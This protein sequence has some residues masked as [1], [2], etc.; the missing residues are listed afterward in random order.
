MNV[1]G[2]NQPS[3]VAPVPQNHP[4]QSRE[5]ASASRSAN[6]EARLAASNTPQDAVRAAEVLDSF[7]HIPVERGT[8]VTYSSEN[9]RGESR[10]LVAGA[11]EE[12]RESLEES[13]TAEIVDLETA[14]NADGLPILPEE[15]RA[16]AL[17]QEIR[18]AYD[19]GRR[20]AEDPTGARGNVQPFDT[21]G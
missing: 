13:R 7:E 5:A 18:E 19:V 9:G 8:E 12:L 15:E 21:L 17:T 16:G 4:R 6:V 20:A 3:N 2:T 1:D 10:G 14:V 11:F